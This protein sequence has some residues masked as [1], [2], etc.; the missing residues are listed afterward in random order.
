MCVELGIDDLVETPLM[1]YI[2]GQALRDNQDVQNRSLGNEEL[3]LY[4]NMVEEY[5]IQKSQ[6]FVR[7]TREARYRPND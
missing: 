6:L 7:T 5:N 4:Y 1:H 3:Q 2:T